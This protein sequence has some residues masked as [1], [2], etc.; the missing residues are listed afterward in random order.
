[1]LRLLCALVCVCVFVSVSVCV[2]C[3]CVDKAF[4]VTKIV[5]K[6][7]L[8]VET[9]PSFP[10]LNCVYL[11]VCVCVYVCASNVSVSVSNRDDLFV[12]HPVLG[13]SSPSCPLSVNLF[14]PSPFSLLLT[15][16]YSL[17]LLFLF[18]WTLFLFY[19][20]TS[21]TIS[22][23]LSLF[24]LLHHPRPLTSKS[25]PSPLAKERLGRVDRREASSYLQREKMWILQLLT[26]P[27]VCV[28]VSV[29]CDHKS[30]TSGWQ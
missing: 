18:L 29:S 14:C 28:P 7:L 4:S 12:Q 25:F 8:S 30:A 19:L 27:C 11:Y 10:T 15:L 9:F 3:V 23:I 22:Y 17:I 26:K 13:V 24:F 2:W 16:S 5:L 6:W 21:S 1:M 20:S